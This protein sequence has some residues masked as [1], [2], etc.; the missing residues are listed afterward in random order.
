MSF[1]ESTNI[2]L[3]DGKKYIKI[4]VCGS[5]AECLVWI[6]GGVII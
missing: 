1:L 5:V 2:L 4:D 3:V 6:G